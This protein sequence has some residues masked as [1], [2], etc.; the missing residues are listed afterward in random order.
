LSKLCARCIA[1]EPNP[2]QARYLRRAFGAKLQV[3][4]LALSDQSGEVEF[5]IPTGPNDDKAG[6]ATIAPGPW[7]SSQAVRRIKVATRRL[8][9]L[10][11][12]PVGF[13]KLDVEGHELAVLR[14]GYKLLSRDRPN[15]LVELEERFGA[16]TIEQ[17]RAYLADI[18]YQGYFL[19]G[20]TL[21][22]ISG[23]DA[24]AYQSMANWG[25]PGLY[26]NNFVFIP[27]DHQAAI[28]ER[29]RSLGYAL[30]AI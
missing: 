29:L 16:G 9:E 24:A 14:G 17:S 1:F 30:E 15:L 3:E 22:H 5:V 26:I 21:R 11:L 13:I 25:I 10:T 12:D 19:T 18:G 4:S 8:D 2:E 23:F 20:H 28:R 6:L 27:G 7:L